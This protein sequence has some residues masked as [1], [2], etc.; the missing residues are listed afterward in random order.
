MKK[1]SSLFVGIILSF[2][3]ILPVNAKETVNVYL[4][5]GKG[6]PHCAAEKEYLEEVA[7]ENKNVKIIYYEVWYDENNKKLFEDVREKLEITRTGVPLTIIGETYIVG[8]SEAVNAKIDR[9]I[10]FYTEREHKDVV[11]EIKNGTYVKSETDSD[12]FLEQEKKSDEEAT[13]KVPLIGSINLKNVSLSTAALILGL[14]D[15]FNPCAMWVLLFLISM[16]IGMK[17]KKRMW[18]IGLTF[19]GSSAFIYMLI[20][21]SWLN[22]VVSIST[23]ILLRNIVAIVAVGGGLWNLY[24]FIKH[25]D[26]GCSVVDAK[27]RKSVFERIKKFTKE[28]SLLLALIGTIALAFSVNI[29]ELACSAGLPLV[30]TQLLSLNKITG[31][32]AFFY[33]LLYTLFF[34][35][36]DLIV[37]FGAMRTME[38]TGISTK[39]SKYSHL[40]GGIL[41]I[42]IGLL[43]I[44]K[45]EWLMFQF[46]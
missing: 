14:I 9:A 22:L 35:L 37:F 1:F 42:M 41:M 27:K 38:V 5:Y 21:M 36:D 6:C 30:F 28:K 40:I 2:L 44:F 24:S 20:M 26:S 23:S 7:K 43:L 4:F 18:I 15:G 11:T 16:L 13:V 29:I 19:L 8:Y 32:G 33:V 3:I 10:D 45:P 34:L 12:E 31:L 17:D 25:Q 46:N 39:Y